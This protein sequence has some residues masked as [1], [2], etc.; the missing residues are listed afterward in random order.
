MHAARKLS[1]RVRTRFRERVATLQGNQPAEL[2]IFIHIPK[3]AGTS[4][5][6]YIQGCVGSRSSGRTVKLSEL[7]HGK[8]IDELSLRRAREARFCVGHIS[9]QSVQRIRRHR[10]AYTFT[11][12]REPMERLWSFYNFLKAGEFPDS[13][14]PPEL[15]DL[16]MDAR[17]WTPAEFVG[18]RDER[19]LHMIDNIMVRQLGGSLQDDRA[20][21]LH[22][23]ALLQAAKRNLATID[24][25]GFTDCFDDDF[26]AITSALDLPAAAA[27]PRVK[28]SQPWLKTR[29][30]RRR[31]FESFR[32]SIGNDADWLVRWDQQLYHFA[33]KLKRRET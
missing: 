8:P 10:H 24:H 9:W 17:S 32:D 5:I 18:T 28:V 6:E 22:T 27:V 30:E 31:S 4:L 2:G 33:R 25:V 16:Y 26:S 7:V 21:G 12:L 19:L 23:P 3:T 13:M 14:I 29:A 11:V 15:F 1:L 20:G